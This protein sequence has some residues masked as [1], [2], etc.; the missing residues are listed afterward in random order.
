MRETTK[1]DYAILPKI[2]LHRHLEGHFHLETLYRMSRKNHLDFPDQFDDFCKMVQFPKNSPPD[3]HLF[4]SK[5]YNGWYSDLE[6]VYYVAYNSMKHIGEGENL[7]YLELRFNP[8]HYAVKQGFDPVDTL[9]VV[10]DALNRAVQEKK[11]FVRYLL[12]F[13]RGFNTAQEMIEQLKRYQEHVDLSGVVGIDLAGDEV[14]Y[15]PELFK[16]FFDYSH[17]QGFQHTIHAA[18]VTPAD[19]VWTAIRDLH[20][21][22]IGHGIGACD[23]K[24]LLQHMKDNHITFEMCP[25]SNHQTAAWA[26]TATHPIKRLLEQGVPVTLNSDDPTVQNTTLNDEYKTAVETMGMSFDQLKLM[27]KT[28]IDSSFLDDASKSK[29]HFSFDMAWQDQLDIINN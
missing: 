28:A 7:H 15:P 24:N 17:A 2:E 25:I 13:N 3:F 19:Q 12:T 23:D 14:K 26:D 22:R 1:I 8:M 16:D 29:L 18:E 9:S 21:K 20:A 5:F 6:D 11:Y 10:I 4:L 27:N